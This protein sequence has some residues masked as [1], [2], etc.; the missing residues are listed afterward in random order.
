M[1]DEICIEDYDQSAGPSEPPKLLISQ[2]LSFITSTQYRL[3]K[4]TFS[5]LKAPAP[6]N[7]PL[8]CDISH[9]VLDKVREAIV[10]SVLQ[11][12]SLLSISLDIQNE[13]HRV[14]TADDEA[15]IQQHIENHRNTLRDDINRLTWQTSTDDDKMEYMLPGIADLIFQ[16]VMIQ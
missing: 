10:K 15:T 14:L 11:N 3:T 6:Y 5:T 7:Y 8:R 16:Y 13:G 1:L 4:V 9:F 12:N 2:L